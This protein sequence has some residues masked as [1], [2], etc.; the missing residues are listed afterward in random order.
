MER[1]HPS[2]TSASPSDAK[3]ERESENGTE[4]KFEVVAAAGAECSHAAQSEPALGSLARAAQPIR[5]RGGTPPWSGRR[6]HARRD[7]WVEGPGAG[8]GP[9]IRARWGAVPVR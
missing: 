4:S 8:M 2:A 5:W 1:Q 6:G 3:S 7:P 9:R